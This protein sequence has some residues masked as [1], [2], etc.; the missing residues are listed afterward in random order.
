MRQRQLLY[1]NIRYF[2][3]YYRLVAMAAA[4]TV[5][6]I[7]GS[8]VVGDSVR[9]TL[10]RRVAERLGDTETIIFSRNSFIS[11]SILSASPLGESSRGVLLTD[12]FISRGGKLVPV[13]VWGVDD[14]SLPE[15]SAKINPALSEELVL[16]ASEDLVLRLP[17]TG[18]VPSGSLF[19]TKNYTTSLRL[20]NGGILSVE[21]GGSLNLRNEQVLPLNVFV[22]RKFLVEALDV[23][24]KINLI[25]TDR[26]VSSTEL[27]GIWNPSFSG[28]E[29]R[30]KADFTEIS[31]DRI[32][33]RGQ[34]VETICRDNPTSNRLFSYLANSIERE[35]VASIPY[36]FITAMDR[37]KDHTL[38]KDEVLL[39][40]YA[41]GRLGVRPGDTL[42]ISYYKSEG[43]KRLGEDTLRLRVR[44]IVPLSEWLADGSLSADFPGLSD[45][46]R[47][48]D[49]DSD[50]PIDMDR[51]TDEDEHYWNLYRSA[52]KAIVAYDAVSADWANAY[53]N[54][55]AIRISGAGA[56]LTGLHPDMFGIQLTHPRETGIYAARNGVDFAGLF[57]ALG[58]F[59]IV[60]AVLLMLN[61]LSEMFYQ[62]RHEIDL[63]RSIGYSR[64]RIVDML[65][66]ESAPIVLLVSAVGVV[67]GLLYTGLVMWLLG[68]VW[69]GATQTDGFRVYPGMWTLVGGTLVSVGLSLGFLRWAIVRTLRE[70]SREVCPPGSS[71]RKKRLGVIVASML[72]IVMIGVN[73]WLLRSVPLF[74]IIGAA[75]IVTAALGGDYWVARKGSE[76][77]SVLNRNQLVWSTIYA[78]RK[79]A[80]LSFFALS[81]GTFIVF[82]V[83]LNRK[84]FGDSSQI[85]TGTG[86]YSLWCESSVPVYYD[87]STPEGKA[88]LSLSDLPEDTEIL[89]CLRYN[90]DDA[91]CLNLNKVTTPTVLGVNMKA[92]SN[93]DFRIE[94]TIYG[95][96]EDLIFERMRERTNAVYPA[97]VDATV[98]TW[99]IGM[100][101]GDTLYYKG[102]L[103]QSVAIR[104]VGTL[105]NS[106][107]QGNILMDQALFS[108]I[109]TETTGSEVFLLKT[110][111]SR[112]EE[113]KTLLSQAL[114]EYGV[115]VTTT[116]DRLRQFNTVTDTYLTIFMTL[117]GLGLLL[118]ILSF[119]IVIRKNLAMRGDEIRLYRT[120]GFPD[121]VIERIFCQENILVPLYAILAGVIGALISV[122]VNFPNAGVGAWLLA[123]C[124]TLFFVGCVIGFVRRLVRRE[125]RN[126]KLIIDRGV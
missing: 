24:G 89:Q 38:G 111:E 34:A 37:Y 96:S 47:C 124:F 67:M 70:R 10:V 4:I 50:L 20:S 39:S 18:M 68:G 85:R 119:I 69:Q 25:R 21:E 40:D 123:F 55:T 74:M 43:L 116:N 62:R 110:G 30:R 57:L 42:R 51:I 58:F 27:D 66:R 28:L 19:V 104:L 41:A 60:S 63:L 75:W 7:V 115:R 82:S 121:R 118:G 92:L 3:R 107:F 122:G 8:L 90:A 108:E 84:G 76:R 98:L 11:D 77:S 78:N 93:S 29:I 112:K 86:G 72:T 83:G 103:G 26:R 6:V 49:W 59:I 91:S 79:Q 9:M 48:T 113:V 99:G 102:D 52:P 23:E 117:G 13:S 2:A 22:S 12:G 106:V 101:L 56:D 64:K 16:G 88:K 36:S 126:S 61:P 87:L 97:L 17:A 120:L 95:G 73:V 109:W 54:A 53:G 1:Q 71:L 105:S 45:V 65:W 32:F 46:E 15:G 81:I 33:L 114:S 44:Q 80:L 14:L 5:A 100:N 31:S 125:V 94:Q 35:G